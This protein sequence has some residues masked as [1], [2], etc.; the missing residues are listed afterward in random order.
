MIS[1]INGIMRKLDGRKERV[2]FVYGFCERVCGSC[3]STGYRHLDTSRDCWNCMVL[4]R[5][6]NISTILFGSYWMLNREDLFPKER[7]VV[8]YGDC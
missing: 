7:V 3:Y 5:L 8:N 2:L 1:E 6:D 4:E